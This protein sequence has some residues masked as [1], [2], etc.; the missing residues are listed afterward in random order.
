MKRLPHVAILLVAI[1][2]VAAD[3]GEKK[4]G[5]AEK[6]QG[7]WITVEVYKKGEKATVNLGN[8]VTFSGKK[9][10][11]GSKDTLE[12]TFKL[13]SDK[14]PR[15]LDLIFSDGRNVVKAIY[16]LS[17]DTLK[18]CWLANIKK[19]PP[20]AFGSTADDERKLFVLKR[21]KGDDKK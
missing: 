7:K 13:R 10:I 17:G 14:K 16:E 5:D 4:K 11:L 15:E 19:G 20:D 9:V 18:M 21:V 6:I 3:K 8:V 1:A 2:L 12:G